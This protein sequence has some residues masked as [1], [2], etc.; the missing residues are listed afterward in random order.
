M[1]DT[2]TAT[3]RTPRRA[4]VAARISKSRLTHV[5]SAGAAR[6]VD[7]GG[8]SANE[9]RALAHSIVRM[10]ASTLAQLTAGRA[11]KGSWEAVLGTARIAGILAAK[12]TSELIPLCHALALSAVTVD[13][14][15]LDAV[16]IE[17]RAEVRTVDRTGV[18]MEAL[19][20]AAVAALTLYDMVKA[21]DKGVVIGDLALLEKDGGKSGPWRR[22]RGKR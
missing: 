11:A 2:M 21:L 8:K 18:E 7:V 3:H 1:M 9:R 20:A 6:M 22:A 19:T 16:R 12:K 15:V 14:V 5:D 17:I 13:F 4:R 10:G